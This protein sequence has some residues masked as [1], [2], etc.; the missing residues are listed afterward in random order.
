[1]CIRDRDYTEQLMAR[2]RAYCTRHGY[3][4]IRSN[5]SFSISPYWIKVALFKQCIESPDAKYIVWLDSDAVID[6]QAV[7]IEDL[8]AASHVSIDFWCCLC[9]PTFLFEQLAT[10]FHKD[11]INPMSES[12]P[13]EATCGYGRIACLLI[14][15]LGLSTI[16]FATQLSD[17]RTPRLTYSDNGAI[18]EAQMQAWVQHDNWSMSVPRYDAD[19]KSAVCTSENKDPIN[20]TLKDEVIVWIAPGDLVDLHTDGKLTLPVNTT[21]SIPHL[22][23]VFGQED[24][25]KVC[26]RHELLVDL[27]GDNYNSTNSTHCHI[28]GE[29]NSV[30]TFFLGYDGALYCCFGRC[31]YPGA[32]AWQARP[33]AF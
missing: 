14:A 26:L 7:R 13:S 12:R 33:W 17:A 19:K 28:A 18:S 2:N 1:M 23:Y 25:V 32:G 4:Y 3:R 21:T 24:H 10:Y 30:I 15:S 5:D 20:L 31:S 6:Q 9:I 22:P 29:K 27:W 8:F 11:S 16:L